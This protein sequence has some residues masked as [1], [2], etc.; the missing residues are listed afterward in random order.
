MNKW[1]RSGISL[2]TW[3]TWGTLVTIADVIP[4][5][6]HTQITQASEQLFSMLWE[7][8][9]SSDDIIFVTSGALVGIL[10]YLLLPK[11]TTQQPQT[12]DSH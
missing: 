5:Q 7:H 8:H 1:R 11:S 4:D 10:T 9:P 6:L 2:A 3:I 12:I